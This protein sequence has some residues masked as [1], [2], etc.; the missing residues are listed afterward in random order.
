MSTTPRL[1]I[2]EQIVGHAR[3]SEPSA[4]REL[5]AQGVDLE[6][7]NQWS[8]TWLIEAITFDHDASIQ[9][10]L[11]AGADPNRCDAAGDPPLIHAIRNENLEAI[12]LLIAHGANPK[13]IWH[14][15]TLIQEA[16]SSLKAIEIIDRLVAAGADPQHRDPAGLSVADYAVRRLRL[17]V[18][19][20]LIQRH[21]LPA[22]PQEAL[23]EELASAIRKGA[24][25]AIR[26]LVELGA[27]PQYRHEGK[28]LIQLAG[29]NTEMKRVIRSVRADQDVSNALKD[30]LD[31]QVAPD[32][33]AARRT[34][35]NPL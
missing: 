29:S 8:R 7:Y 18:A 33:M 14:G 13:L 32:Q 17:V 25:N 16:I 19:K 31:G 5:I 9:L 30:G 15:R 22:P 10:L 24:L 6:A 21:G 4:M 11:D 2:I 34:S 35:F 20:H 27:D 26:D 23:N 12:D 3:F 1:S 28:T